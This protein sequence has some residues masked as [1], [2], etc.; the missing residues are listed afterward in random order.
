MR[1]PKL[2]DGR[3]SYT[4]VQ[5]N[6]IR[7]LRKFGIDADAFT[8]WCY[9]ASRTNKD[10]EKTFPAYPLITQEIGLTNQRI[11]KAIRSLMTAKLLQR[12]KRKGRSNIYEVFDPERV[13]ESFRIGRTSPSGVVGLV[14]PMSKD[15]ELKLK[16]LNTRRKAARLAARR[17]RPNP[18]TFQKSLDPTEDA[19]KIAR[20][21]LQQELAAVCHID[22]DSNKRHVE[23]LVTK[24]SQKDVTAADLRNWFGKGSWWFRENFKGKQGAYPNLF[25]IAAT[26]LQAK[27][28]SVPRSRNGNG[29][30][31]AAPRLRD[32]WRDE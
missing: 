4:V 9:L 19:P 10:T 1:S 8:L 15:K 20:L 26:W 23:Q 16:E 5:D 21:E 31:E 28:A 11:A 3:K 18:D 7:N 25:D 27:E 13:P 2:K 32:L 22:V 29:S 24:L 6:L 30:A 17:K 14:L 12:E